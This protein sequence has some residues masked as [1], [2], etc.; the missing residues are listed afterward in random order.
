MLDGTVYRIYKIKECVM[1]S[2]AYVYLQRALRMA[3]SQNKNFH[4]IRDVLKAANSAVISDQ[5][6][7]ASLRRE[8]SS[9]IQQAISYTYSRTNPPPPSP[10]VKQTF[11]SMT[12][13]ISPFQQNTQ[14][15]FGYVR[16]EIV[17]GRPDLVPRAWTGEFR[18]SN[19]FVLMIRKALII[20]RRGLR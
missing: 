2:E 10:F 4:V 9:A 13:P 5:T 1:F 6:Q 8:A 19:A 15:P 12:T 16:G 3:S 17:P 20:V 18:E 11:Q 7:S 14:G